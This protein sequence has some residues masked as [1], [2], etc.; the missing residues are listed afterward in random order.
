[1]SNFIVIQF[2]DISFILKSKTA[3]LINEEIV[4]FQQAVDPIHHCEAF[5]PKQSHAGGHG[6]VGS[7]QTGKKPF[8]ELP[9]QMQLGL[10][11]TGNTAFGLINKLFKNLPQK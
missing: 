1:L 2:S 7:W 10:I 5:S 9:T 4:L 11:K 8:S 3:S 6:F